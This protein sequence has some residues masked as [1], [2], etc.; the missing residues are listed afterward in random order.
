MKK[1]I[2]L[3]INLPEKV[4]KTLT[5][6]QGRWQDFPVRWVKPESLHLTLAFLGYISDEE[7]SKICQE[8]KGIASEHFS[9]FINLN[10][11]DYD[12]Q[13]KKM[14]RLIWAIG[15]KSEQLSSLKKDLD[16][17][18]D[19]TI[20][21][22][23]ERKDFLPHITLGR[24][25]QWQWSKIETEERPQIKEDLFLDFQVQSIE[26]MESRLRRSGAEYTILQSE[27]L[28]KYE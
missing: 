11:I 25:K 16:G 20:G 21:F 26:V 15:E 3:A 27:L 28:K 23:P 19:N 4:K 7:L 12:V 2:F 1:R 9:F 22:L 18:L 10:Q 8:L 17:F 24:I 5:D 14:P 13:E 6:Y